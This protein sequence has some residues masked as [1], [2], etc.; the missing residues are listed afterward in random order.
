MLFGQMSALV[1]PISAVSMGIV[2]WSWRYNL[3]NQFERP[4][5]FGP[6]MRLMFRVWVYILACCHIVMGY[7]VYKKVTLPS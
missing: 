5:N 6:E 4:P 1:Y 2:Y 7:W 3:A